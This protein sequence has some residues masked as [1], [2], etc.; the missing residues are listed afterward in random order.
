MEKIIS[1]FSQTRMGSYHAEEVQGDSYEITVEGVYYD[2]LVN[3]GQA[4]RERET[5]VFPM[6]KAGASEALSKFDALRKTAL[7]VINQQA[8]PS[9]S[10]G[11]L[12]EGVDYSI[13]SLPDKLWT[14][15]I[16]EDGDYVETIVRFPDW[17]PCFRHANAYHF[18]LRE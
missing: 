8:S 16:T 12:V 13:L 3:E 18:P 4:N 7:A 1:D 11:E 15:Y 10:E 6:T 17:F 5:Y 14:L 2:C 9:G